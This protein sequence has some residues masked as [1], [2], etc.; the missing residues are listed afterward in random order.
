MT[1]SL[2]AVMPKAGESREEERVRAALDILYQG[3]SLLIEQLSARHIAIDDMQ[4]LAGMHSFLQPIAGWVGKM[5][6]SRLREILFTAVR[7]TIESLD[8]LSIQ[9]PDFLKDRPPF[10]ADALAQLGP[11]ITLSPDRMTACVRMDETSAKYWTVPRLLDSLSLWGVQRDVDR[12]NLS[13]LLERRCFGRIIPVAQGRLP[14]PGRDSVI[15]TLLPFE[16]KSEFTNLECDDCAGPCDFQTVSRNQP[17][18]RKKAASSG[19]AGWDVLGQEIAAAAG[20]NETLPSITHCIADASGLELRSDIDG[21]AYYIKGR[22]IVSPALIVSNSIDGNSDPVQAEEDVVVL[23]DIAAD[24]EVRSKGYVAVKG[25]VGGSQIQAGKSI[26]GKGGVNGR[27]KATLTAAEDICFQFINGTQVQAG[28]TVTAK[29]SILQSEVQARQVYCPNGQIFGGTISAWKTVR[30]GTLGAESGVKTEIVLGAE[31]PGLQED[32]KRLE[33]ELE[34]KKQERDKV[35]AIRKALLKSKGKIE[36]LTAEDKNKI[37]RVSLVLNKLKKDVDS[38]EMRL[39]KA[40]KDLS[41]SVSCQRSVRVSQK[42]YPGTII[43]IMDRTLSVQREMGPS[44][45]FCRNGEWVTEPYRETGE[46]EE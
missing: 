15:E 29:A 6:A 25:T 34:S 32:V 40:R 27:N 22:L 17:I 43:T 16:K 37:A 14:K 1:S 42:I 8:A 9:F 33:S 18:L 21:C 10:I 36:A 7:N 26:I 2:I 31:L 44:I 41:F 12:S 11:D 30:A 20:L 24:C 19:E 46:D 5:P 3:I 13:A 38:L 35:V 39:E 23:G 4:N 28:R 45:I